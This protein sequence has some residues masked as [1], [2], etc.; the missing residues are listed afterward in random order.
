MAMTLPLS[1]T[2]T[3]SPT[4]SASPETNPPHTPASPT[5][6][7]SGS[8]A[9]SSSSKESSASPNAT[10]APATHHPNG[11]PI[12]RKPSRR[13]NT[14]ERRATHNAVERA[15]RETLNSRFLDL[16]ALL[17]N[18]SQI[19]RPSKSAIVNSSIAHIHAAR[20]HRALAARELRVLKVETDALR[21]E[22]NEW[23]DRAG[24]P[25]VEE[26]PRGE[27]FAIV[28]SGEVEVLPAPVGME[29]GDEE[30]EEEYAPQPPPPQQPQQEEM[31]HL[32]E[33]RA[34]AMLKAGAHPFAHSVPRASIL[35]RAPLAPSPF[36]H[37][38]GLVQGFGGAAFGGG[39][40]AA[41][42]DKVAAWHMHLY[43]TMQG[44]AAPGMFT[45]PQSAHGVSN[46]NNGN[47][48]GNNGGNGNNNNNA[49]A[50]AFFANLH[51]QQQMMGTHGPMYGSPVDGDDGSSVSS[52][53][54]QH[55]A[56]ARSQSVG[57]VGGV[58][59][60]MPEFAGVPR[61]MGAWAG[62]EGM[63]MGMGM[64]GGVGMGMGM[65]MGVGVGMKTLAVGGGNGGFAMMM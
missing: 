62:G 58:G 32:E 36:D 5:M 1:I 19:R 20:R 38:G 28:A 51:R 9:A 6:P 33:L 45:P 25:R 7:D 23:R 10:S 56:R 60:E 39:P 4:S 43:Q 37:S 34:V 22:L 53:A 17:P 3:S 16:A 55:Q 54:S 41:D 48:N 2:P 13:A 46:N 14:A 24:L 40:A 12:K 63:M 27:G 15:R 21:R 65:G 57:G 30:D 11:Q 64:G 42:V 44:G 31:V 8:P 18:L 29:L 47:G 59:G 35:P 49:Q 52:A 50:A 61:R 26:P